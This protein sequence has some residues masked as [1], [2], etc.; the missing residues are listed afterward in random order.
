MTGVEVI[1]LAGVVLPEGF[2]LPPLPYLVGLLLATLIVGTLLYLIKPPVTGWDVVALGAWMAIGGALHALQQVGAFPPMVEPLME[3]PAVYLTAFVI[4]GGLWLVA[5]IANAAGVV[6]S[7]PR[8]VGGV[9]VLVG[10]VLVAFAI[11]LGQ[12]QGTLDPLWPSIGLF[13]SVLVAAAAFIGLSLTYTDAVATTGKTGALVVFAHT[14]DGVSTA[15]GMDVLGAGERSP[16]PQMI[17]DVAAGLPTAEFIGVGWLFVLVK[18]LL[19]VGVVALFTDYV[20][21]DPY[22]G[23]ILLAA[24]AAFGLG[25]GVHNLLLFL[26]SGAA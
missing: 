24:V 20:K 9:G 12:T 22:R 8:L 25:P 11:V 5:T 21:E 17:M 1:G 4:A 15:I 13:A 10:I 18:I 6:G 3:A 19:A 16:L 14:L 2:V 26:V 23:N 7:A